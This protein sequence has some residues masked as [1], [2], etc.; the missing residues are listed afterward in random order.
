MKENQTKKK[1]PFYIRWWFIVA[2]IIGLFII[3]LVTND[4]FRRGFEDGVAPV[5]QHEIQN[6]ENPNNAM[7][8]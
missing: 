4:E 1:K 3:F 2:V 7:S 6:E 8:G 5:S